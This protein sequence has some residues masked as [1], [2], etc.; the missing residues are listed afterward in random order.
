M[1]EFKDVVLDHEQEAS[2][3][4]LSFVVQKGDI[5]CVCGGV[6][7]GKSRLAHAA[8]GLCGVAKGYV[9]WE[10]EEVNALSAS[11][12]R[13]QMGYI[14]SEVLPDRKDGLSPFRELTVERL[15]R[16]VLSLKVCDKPMDEELLMQ[17]WNVLSLPQDIYGSKCCE[18]S[19][20]VL[21]RVLLSAVPQM[22]KQLL[23]ADELMTGQTE[24]DTRQIQ[25]FLKMQA[26]SGMAI[27]LTVLTEG[28]LKYVRNEYFMDRITG[29]STLAVDTAG[30]DVA[31]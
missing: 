22:N 28:P 13:K 2:I 18:L 4:P 25:T 19:A 15:L 3:A 9:T 21:K 20:G 12:L 26:E 11:A 29:R 23:V 17:S 8:L 31:L 24:E 1:L 10:G 27:L 30:G 16:S 5:A 7:S 6:R 14:P